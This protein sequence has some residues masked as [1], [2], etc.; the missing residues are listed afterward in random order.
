MTL[1]KNPQAIMLIL[2]SM[3]LLKNPQTIMLILSNMA[4]PKKTSNHN[5]HFEQYGFT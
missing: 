2:S 1:P 5:A 3:T 4:L